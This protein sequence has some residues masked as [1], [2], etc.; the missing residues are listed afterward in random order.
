MRKQNFLCVIELLIAYAGLFL[1]TLKAINA[2]ITVDE[3]L[4][5][6]EAVC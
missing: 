3:S 6:Y 2:P 4:T 1:A 5:Y